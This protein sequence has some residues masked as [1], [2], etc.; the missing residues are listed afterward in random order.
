MIYLF[1]IQYIWLFIVFVHQIRQDCSGCSKRVERWV[2]AT[3]KYRQSPPC[4]NYTKSS[5]GGASLGI[6]GKTS[7]PPWNPSNI[8]L[9]YR[10]E[11]VMGIPQLGPNYVERGQ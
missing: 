1:I 10:N 3:G 6:M 8:T 11:G 9:L 5:R 4:K 7:Q 2:T